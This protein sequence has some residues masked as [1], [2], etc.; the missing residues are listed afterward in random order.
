MGR[1]ALEAVLG[2]AVVDRQGRLAVRCVLVVAALLWG[3]I[4]QAAQA[5]AV[6]IGY[7]N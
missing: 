1:N 6:G 5:T 7:N 2:S 4:A 3:F